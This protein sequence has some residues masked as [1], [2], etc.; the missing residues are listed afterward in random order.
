MEKNYCIDCLTFDSPKAVNFSQHFHNNAEILIF[1][2]GDA[3]YEVE[4]QTFTLDPYDILIIPAN[5]L[6]G[7]RHHSDKKYSRIVIR[8]DYDFFENMNC[9]EYLNIINKKNG[10][11]IPGFVVEISGLPEVLSNFREYSN[12]FND[13]YTKISEACLI[14]FLHI[15]NKIDERSLPT[16]RNNNIQNVISYINKEYAN[17]INLDYLAEKFFIS[18]F[19]LCREFKKLT[20][21]TI[22]DYIN[23]KKLQKVKELC[24]SGMNISNS[25]ISAGF[26]S[27]SAFYRYYKKRYAEPPGSRLKK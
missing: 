6:H 18:K 2:E 10:I 22:H 1:L 14:Q 7:I 13:C 12:N 21:H 17:E 11:K 25:C 19:H 15:L 20:G 24:N 23:I 4:A 8:I 27:Y 9:T 26:N 5:K 3:S 16:I